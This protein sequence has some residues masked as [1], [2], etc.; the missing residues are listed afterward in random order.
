[1]SIQFKAS[2]WPL[3]AV[4]AFSAVLAFAPFARASYPNIYPDGACDLNY[5]WEHGQSSS[6][7]IELQRQGD[8]AILQGIQTENDTFI[9]EGLTAIQWAL[10]HQASDGSWA[11]TGDAFH[12]TC[13]F[14]EGTANAMIALR[15]YHPVTYSKSYAA[16]VQEYL[17][18]LQKGSAWLTS[19]SILSAGLISDASFNHRRY[20][21]GDA[22]A[23]TAYLAGD[24]ASMANS[25]QFIKDGLAEQWLNGVDPESGGYDVGYEIVSTM[26]AQHY[27]PMTSD[28]TL[29]AE[30]LRMISRSLVWECGRVNSAGDIDISGSTRTG[31]ETNRDG[32]VKQIAREQVMTVF[33]AGYQELKDSRFLCGECEIRQATYPSE[34]TA[35]SVNGAVGTNSAFD[36][37]T[38]S[39]YD[40]SLQ[41]AGAD[42]LENGM[43]VQNE[44]VADKGQLILSWGQSRMVDS[45]DS[46]VHAAYGVAKFSEGLLRSKGNLALFA[47]VIPLRP[48]ILNY[49][50]GLGSSAIFGATWLTGS[51]ATKI[52]AAEDAQYTS[53][54][55]LFAAVCARA[56]ALEN[57]AGLAAAANAFAEKAMALQL[58]NGEN[59]E[60][61]AAS[62]NNQAL[63]I[64]YAAEF[65]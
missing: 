19:P 6:W 56:A 49:Y 2:S 13:L 11:G 20:L 24:E 65:F 36:A 22:V 5:A 59:P 40:L 43:S 33:Q 57:D 28:P 9:Q 32:V 45:L 51:A 42:W 50:V 35:V 44:S 31:R 34:Q 1:M 61:S 23:E 60:N 21:L 4:G 16:T 38:P 54:Q 15:E 27:L 25:V 26:F 58:S 46:A 3:R 18:M 52:E 29:T 17:P 47:P 7:Y 14:V 30:L 48:T 12:S 39:K 37:G 8:Y 62:G 10:K 63:G 55:W 41:G 64:L 53:H